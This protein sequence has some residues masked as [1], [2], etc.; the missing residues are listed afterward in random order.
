MVCHATDGDIPPPKAHDSFD[1]P[2]VQC[3]LVENAALLDMEFH[4]GGHASFLPPCLGEPGGV[5]AEA[6]NALPHGVPGT[7]D[8]SQ[9]PRLQGS[10]QDA[11]AHYAPLFIGKDDDLQ[12][13]PCDNALFMQGLCHLDGSHGS[14]AAVVIPSVGHHVDMG[15]NSDGFQVLAPRFSPDDISGGVHSG[16]KP[17][18]FHKSHD[19]GAPFQVPV[20]EG[21]AVGLSKGIPAI[22]GEGI[23]VLVETVGIDPGALLGDQV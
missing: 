13:V 3:F 10:C 15:T 12:G 2:D 9:G 19:K 6:L 1:H 14:H 8:H 22:P 17:G 7:V 18:F 20:A 16:F 5:T 11:A 23:Q 4:K 21:D